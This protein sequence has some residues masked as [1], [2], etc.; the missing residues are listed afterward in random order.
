MKKKDVNQIEETSTEN[1]SKQAEDKENLTKTQIINREKIAH[2][3]VNIEKEEKDINFHDLV[4]NKRKTLFG[5]YQKNRRVNNIIMVVEVLFV[6]ASF[7]LIAQNNQAM[8]ITG[9][10]VLF[11]F[12]GGLIAYY[13]ITKN[14]FPNET[15]K[16]IADI[17]LDLDKHL[18]NDDRY[19]DM[20]TNLDRKLEMSDI[21]ADRVYLSPSDIG[22][23]NICEGHF[24]GMRFKAAELALYKQVDRKKRDVVFVGRYLSFENSLKFDG[25]LIINLKGEKNLD[26]PS[27]IED[28]KVLK[29]EGNMTIYGP[30]NFDINSVL[31][32]KT[33]SAIKDIDVR[34]F[35]VNVNIVIWGGHS[36]VYLS[37]DD[38]VVSLPFDKEFKEEPINRVRKD[39][40]NVLSIFVEK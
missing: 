14:R 19:K 35:L 30:E 18:F 8:R 25:R 31:S 10:V 38:V 32:K 26:L 34:D 27:D 39:F 28:L 11:V 4:E 36:A 17:S 40:L 16:Y 20:V 15:K 24:D 6:I 22:S 29:E 9:F 21:T 37:Y 13:A 5:N 3:D 23:R 7:I 1:V 2:P 33:L 12:L